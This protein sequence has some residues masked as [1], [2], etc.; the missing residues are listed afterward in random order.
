MTL[1][2]HAQPGSPPPAAA[3]RGIGIWVGFSALVTLLVG[4]LFVIIVMPEAPSS[5]IPSRG[6]PA[7]PGSSQ[8]PTASPTP[9]PTP[10]PRVEPADSPLQKLGLSAT[11][12]PDFTVRRSAV[13]RDELEGYLNEVL[14]CLTLT[15]RQ[16]FADAG[17]TLSRPSLHPETA[18]NQSRCITDNTS[19]DWA[20]LYCGADEAIYFRPDWAPDDPVF[21]VDVMA[22]EYAHHL[23]ELTGILAPVSEDQLAAKDEPNGEIRSQELSRR[24][25]LQAECVAGVLTRPAGPLGVRQTDFDSLVWARASVPPEWAATHGSGRAQRRWFQTGADSKGPEHYRQCNTFTV[26]ADQVE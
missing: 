1:T 3:D 24:V 13:P 21:L 23:Q 18:M 17:L 16:A 4:A 10:T 11:Q 22:H 25:E 6:A 12:C 15:H 14:D 7:A 26:P 5:A 9:S 2:G 19:D 20:G 8:T